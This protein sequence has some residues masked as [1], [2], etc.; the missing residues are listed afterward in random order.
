MGWIALGIIGVAAAGLLWRLGVARD[1]WA[2]AGAAL[3]LGAAGYALQGRPFQPGS[4]VK[5]NAEPIEVDPGLIALRNAMFGQF[6]LDGA[7]FIAADAMTRSGDAG[8]AV[9][10]MLGGLH[11][12]PQSYS[13]WTGLGLA[14]AT[15]DGGQV[16]PASLFAFR[17]AIRLAPNHPAPR[18]FLGLAYIRAGQFADA[19]PEWARALALTP[20]EASY[21]PDIAF[22]LALLDKYLEL[23]AAPAH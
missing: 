4:P 8:A 6:T 3:M 19:R 11:K 10:V 9:Q 14:Y 23:Q 16:S 15:H 17:Q 18:F 1:L 5:A 12:L 2:F 21:R 7:Y 13:L 20:A 22:R